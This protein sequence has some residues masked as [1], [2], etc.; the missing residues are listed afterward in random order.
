MLIRFFTNSYNSYILQT[1]SIKYEIYKAFDD[2]PS[3]VEK[4]NFLD[5]SNSFEKVSSD[6]LIYKFKSYVVGYKLLNLVQNYLTNRQ[7]VL[8]NGWRSKWTNILR[9]I[10]QGSVLGA[11]LFFVCINELPDSLKSICKIFVDDTSLY[12]KINVVYTSNI[13]INNY[14]VKISRNTY[15][16]KISFNPDINQQATG[17]KNYC[18]YW[19]FSTTT[20]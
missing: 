14:I 4:G 10:P 3:I 1:L 5:I 2:N 18:L 12:S 16:W 19:L 7:R 11:F 15:Q 9:G 6:G 20:M 17:V 8:V 13:D